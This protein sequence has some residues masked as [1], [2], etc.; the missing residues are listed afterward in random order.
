M[1]RADQE[2]VIRIGINGFGRI[3]RALARIIT[4]EPDLRL[5]AINDLTEIENLA[6]LYNY[7]STY[8]R[9][10]VKATSDG[11][12]SL[13]LGDSRAMFSS[14]E[15]ITAVDWS[16]SGV[17]VLIDATGVDRN[18]KGANS[19]VDAG[20][21]KKVIVTHSPPADVDKYV[22]LGVNE[23][24][25]DHSSDHVISSTICDANAIAHV[26]VAIDEEFG[27]ETG[28]VTT[29]HPW[30]SYQNLLDGPVGFQR[31]P[32]RYW[33]EYA[34]GRASVMTMIA[35]ETTAVTALRPIMPE[36]ESKITGISFRTPTNI[37]SIADMSIQVDKPTSQAEVVDFLYERFKD[38]S[39]VHL[40]SEPLIGIDY[41]GQ[42]YSAVVDTNLVRVAGEKL[43]KLVLWYDN[44]WGY[45]CRVIDLARIMHRSA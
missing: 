38:S 2:G 17:D 4:T 36:L 19:L 6:Y 3:G 30:L 45:S 25:I 42:P 39:Y 16:G 34:L 9:A 35:K 14:T 13:L 32:G 1:G 10:T 26:L 12:S 20:S 24:T 8:G 31:F 27:I 22:I 44:E 43:V 23:G 29:L 15:D 7:D 33:G 11:P 28:L 37:V 40:N 21:V 18:V 41:A 5:V